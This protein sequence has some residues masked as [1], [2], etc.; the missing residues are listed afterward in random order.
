MIPFLIIAAIEI[1]GIAVTAYSV[2]DG[3]QVQQAIIDSNNEVMDAIENMPAQME[4]VYYSFTYGLD[5]WSMLCNS[6]IQI[7]L[8]AM[9]LLVAYMI[10]NPKRPFRYGGI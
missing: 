10:V 4:Q 8:I 2:Y 3:Q 6:F 1:V 9:V 7:W 5:F